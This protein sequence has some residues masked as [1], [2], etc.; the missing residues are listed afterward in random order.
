MLSAA[1]SPA[2][3]IA[4]VTP[5]H[6]EPIELPTDDPVSPVAAGDTVQGKY[7]VGEMIGIGGMAAVVAARHL[8]LDQPV[9]IKFLLPEHATRP[10]AVRRFLAEARAAARLKSDHVARV[11]DVGTTETKKGGI[12]PF[13]VMELLHGDD[14]DGILVQRGRLPVAEA[15]EYLLQACDAVSEAHALGIIHRDLKPGNLFLTTRRDGT[16]VIKLLDFGISKIAARGTAKNAVAVTADREM[17]GS[18]GYMSPEQIRSAKDVDARTDVWALGIILHEL[19]TGRGPFLADNVADTLVRVL[20]SAPDRITDRA[21]ETPDGIVDI[22]TRCLQKRP[23]HRFGS[24]D[25]LAAALAPWRSRAPFVVPPFIPRA[26]LTAAS[27]AGV[28]VRTVHDVPKRKI[29]LTALLAFGAIG[30]VL[31]AVAGF[32]RLRGQESRGAGDGTAPATATLLAPTPSAPGSNDPSALP[33]PALAAS[34]T[35]ATPDTPRPSEPAAAAE[36][37]GPGASATT[38]SAAKSS[39]T[40]GAAAKPQSVLGGRPATPSTMAGKPAASAPRHRTDW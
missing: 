33:S 20:H 10:D 2:Y 40:A 25:E 29:L 5:L 1:I 4:Q 23:E 26:E 24:V 11:L 32:S 39:K 14:L 19:L 13:M 37:A 17:M 38:G 35:P 21:P 9:A 36:G 16:G 30:L 18:P 12:V 15:V 6:D 3:A 22:V 31:I 28:S 8:E 27:D 34:V 7:R